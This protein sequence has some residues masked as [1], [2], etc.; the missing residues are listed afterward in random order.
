MKQLPEDQRNAASLQDN[1]RSP[2]Q[3]QQT[4][5]S[6]TAALLAD[7]GGNMDGFYSVLANVALDPADGQAAMIA[8]NPIQAF[9]DCILAKVENDKPAEAEESKQARI[10]WWLWF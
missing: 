10:R 2:A 1:L 8:Q 6:L 9:L 4:L 5:R 7:D 3:V